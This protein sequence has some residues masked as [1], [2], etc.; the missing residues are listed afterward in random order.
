MIKNIKKNKKTIFLKGIFRLIK[1]SQ[2]VNKQHCEILTFEYPNMSQYNYPKI[3]EIKP[4]E[5]NVFFIK[6]NAIHL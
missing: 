1:A 5:N 6:Q 4:P 3:S 2:K